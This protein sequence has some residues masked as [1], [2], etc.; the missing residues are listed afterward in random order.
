MPVLLDGVFMR[1]ATIEDHHIRLNEAP[2]SFCAVLS[3]HP[4][5]HKGL[6]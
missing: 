2:I 1:T 5:L 3:T 4:Q 6:T